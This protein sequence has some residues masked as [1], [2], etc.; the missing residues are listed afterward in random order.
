MGIGKYVQELSHTTYTARPLEGM[1]LQYAHDGVPHYPTA[2]F[3]L[4]PTHRTTA[5]SAPQ[6]SG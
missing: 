4:A 3:Q 1:S 2:H 6:V 5:D